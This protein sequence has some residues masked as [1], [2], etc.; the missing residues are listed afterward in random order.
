M[1]QQ[2]KTVTGTAMYRERIALPA[3]AVFEATLEDVS[4]TDSPAIVIGRTRL[5]K[6]GQ[7][8]FRF[9]IDYDPARVTENHSYVLRARITVDDKLMFSTDQSYPVLTK[10]QGNEVAMMIM[11]R[12]GSSPGGQTG[13][14]AE[15]PVVRRGMFRYMADA[16]NFTDCE[17]RQRWPVAMEGSYKELEAAYLK[18]RRQG[19]EELLVDI[20]GKVAMRP[21][22]EEGRPPIPTVVI[23]RF[24]GIFPGETCGARGATS[25]L[26]ETY[27]K[28]TRLGEKPVILAERQREPSLVFRSKESRVTGFGSC[29]NLTGSYKLN[30]DQITFSGTATTRRACLP[31]M[32]MEGA[33]FKALE[34]VR[35]WKI[36]GEHLELYDATGKMLAR[37]EARALK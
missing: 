15:Q 32:E 11:R 29:N 27:W 26:Q 14:Q 36:S 12:G 8:P 37:F 31:S 9:S 7:P 34:H 19:G 18:T 30:G 2:T 35:T 17:S 10:G 1:A 13:T 24:I 4:G 20:D 33:F 6:P 5:D 25:P 28:L 16:A 23:E 22:M 21:S 3:H